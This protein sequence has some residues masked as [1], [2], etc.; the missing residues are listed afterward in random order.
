MFQ[1]AFIQLSAGRTRLE[2]LHSSS[3]EWTNDFY[4]VLWIEWDAGIAYRKGPR[5]DLRVVLGLC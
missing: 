4:F 5:M 2:H 3:S 1:V